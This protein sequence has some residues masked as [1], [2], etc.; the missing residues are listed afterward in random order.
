MTSAHETLGLDSSASPSAI[1]ERYLELVL[2]HPPDRDPERFAMIHAAYRVLQDPASSLGSLLFELDP[3]DDS[4][5]A[6]ADD[7]WKR[8]VQGRIPLRLLLDLADL[9]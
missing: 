7:I 8:V 9:E 1:R 6:V 4:W 3:R 5:D 2:K